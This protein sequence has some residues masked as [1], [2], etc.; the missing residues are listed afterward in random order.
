MHCAQL[1]W[2]VRFVVVLI[3]PRG[4]DFKVTQLKFLDPTD[5]VGGMCACSLRPAKSEVR[6]EGVQKTR[7]AMTVRREFPIVSTLHP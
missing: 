1:L 3:I 2:V 6:R 5:L 7:Q 4:F